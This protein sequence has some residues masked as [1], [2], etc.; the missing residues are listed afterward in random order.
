[1]RLTK[2]TDYAIVLLAH[3]MRERGR[4]GRLRAREL[5]R[6]TRLPEPMVRKI[7]KELA[8]E[9]ILDSRRGNRGGYTPARSP[10]EISVAAIVEALEGP[11]AMT[12]CS[13]RAVGRCPYE[14][15]CSVVGPLQHLNSVVQQT[16]EDLSL[17]ELLAHSRP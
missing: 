16:L 7:L 10:A 14:R 6:L 15:G 17:A 3:F 8:R 1:M 2:Q 9:G 5:A 12:A 4:A 13:P 11:I